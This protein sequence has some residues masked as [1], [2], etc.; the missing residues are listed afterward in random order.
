VPLLEFAGLRATVQLLTTAELP[1]SA[2]TGYGEALLRMPPVALPE[3]SVISAFEAAQV[4][5]TP[6][7]LAVAPEANAGLASN[8]PYK[9]LAPSPLIPDESWIALQGICGG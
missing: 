3:S 5:A 1:D 8:D 4:P 9:G 2:L 7:A 6:Y